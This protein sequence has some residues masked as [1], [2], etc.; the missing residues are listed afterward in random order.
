[1]ENSIKYVNIEDLL[2]GQIQLEFDTQTK[3]IPFIKRENVTV[4]LL[5][6][7]KK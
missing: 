7:V 3:T 6:I 1:M 2:P 5:C 4:R